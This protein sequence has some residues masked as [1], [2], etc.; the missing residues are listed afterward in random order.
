MEHSH[1][2]LLSMRVPS[3]TEIWWLQAVFC[4]NLSVVIRSHMA[5]KGF[6]NEDLL[7]TIVVRLNIPPPLMEKQNQMLP[8]DVRSAKAIAAVRIHAERAV[9]RLKNYLLL[10]GPS[11]A[12]TIPGLTYWIVFSLLQRRCISS[13]ILFVHK[14]DV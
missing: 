14:I 11:D 9:G 10:C 2:C 13:C 6:N 4:T 12:L 1:S 8:E 5:D 7:I 3:Q